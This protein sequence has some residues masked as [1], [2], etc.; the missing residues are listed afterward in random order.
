MDFAYG[1][2]RPTAG[3]ALTSAPYTEKMSPRRKLLAY[4]LRYR[5]AFLAGLVCVVGT[6]AVGLAGPWVLKLAIDALTRAVDAS[7]ARAYGRAIGAL[8]AVRAVSRM[9]MPPISTGPSRGV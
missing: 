8:A 9:A 2:Y 7:K 1:D 5:G 3:S 6:A 4:V